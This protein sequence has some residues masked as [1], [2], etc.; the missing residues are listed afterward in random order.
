MVEQGDV[1][2]AE[3]TGTVRRAAGGEM[4]MSVAEVFVTRD[5]KIAERRTWVVGPER[6]SGEAGGVAAGEVPAGVSMRPTARAW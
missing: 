4:R 5:S 1:V 3:L 6:T 2:M